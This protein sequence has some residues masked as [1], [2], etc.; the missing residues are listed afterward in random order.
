METEWS[1][2]PPYIVVTGSICVRGGD[3]RAD[4]TRH[5]SAARKRANTIYARYKQRLESIELMRTPFGAVMNGRVLSD[6]KALLAD[7][8]RE[9]RAFNE[10]VANEG[11]H[12]WNAMVCEPLRGQRLTAFKAWLEHHPQEA[13][14]IE[15]A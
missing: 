1:D 7:A 6:A 9:V 14:K 15:A 8:E 12:I 4:G 5:L 3:H 13:A 11:C 2:F 10:N